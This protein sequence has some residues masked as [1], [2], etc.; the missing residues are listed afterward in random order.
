MERDVR[1][2][3]M[4]DHMRNQG[5]MEDLQRPTK[6]FEYHIPVTPIEVCMHTILHPPMNRYMSCTTTKE[7]DVLK[8]TNAFIFGESVTNRW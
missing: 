6:N 4:I 1:D 2:G 3:I 8:L 7:R 5:Y